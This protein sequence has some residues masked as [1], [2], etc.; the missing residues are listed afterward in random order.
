MT[1]NPSLHSQFDN[2][3]LHPQLVTAIDRAERH[4]HIRHRLHEFSS[5][6]EL[7]AERQ[8]YH[9]LLGHVGYDCLIVP[10]LANLDELVKITFLSLASLWNSDY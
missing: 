4:A 6:N 10:S 2:E 3:V 7:S 1:A 8:M 5:K 9:V